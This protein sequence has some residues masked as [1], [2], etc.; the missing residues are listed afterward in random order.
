ML[1][2]LANAKTYL[3]VSGSG[4]DATITDMI[5]AAT[6]AMEQFTGRHLDSTTIT[7]Y[8]NGTGGRLLWLKE[9][10]ESI[11]NLWNDSAHAWG[12]ATLVDA[13]DYLLTGCEVDYLDH[14]WSEGRRNIKVTYKAG[15]ATMPDDLQHACK[16]QVAKLYSEWQ[17]AKKGLNVLA[18][19]TVQ[20]WSQAF[21]AHRGLDPEVADIVNRYK[22]ARL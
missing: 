16:V 10:A 12:A 19:H 2:T 3:G 7:E 9:P 11:T 13:D 15:Y 22:P 4:D 17:V 5:E 8:L 6:E 14:I 1:V 21:L 18:S 20:G